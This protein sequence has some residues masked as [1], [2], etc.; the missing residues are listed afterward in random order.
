MNGK[1]MK[2]IALAVL[3]VLAVI[4]PLIAGPYPQSIMKTV[5][6]YMA[7]ALAWDILLRSG[8]L[9]FGIAGFYGLGAYA[10]VLAVIHLPVGSV[11][12]VLIGGV[13]SALVAFL[14]GVVILRLRAMYFAITTL[15]LGEIFR[16]IIRN[17]KGFAGGPEGLILPSVAFDGASWP[18]YLL[19]LA[20][21]LIVIG[22]SE[23]IEKGR[24]R[25]SLTAIR[26]N[27]IVAMSR[28]V[29]V[30]S[31]LLKVFILSSALMG[32]A[33][34]AFAQ[35]YGFVTPENTFS[36]DYTL[37]PLAMALLGGIYGTWGPVIGALVLGII[38]EYLRLFIPYGHLIVYGIIIILVIL[39]M[40]HGFV[41]L[42][43]DL[44]A[45]RKSGKKDAGSDSESEKEVPA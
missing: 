25:F 11:G 28:G 39:F 10:S 21:I 20:V 13:F 27:E 1:T 18:S 26:N 19:V 43:R 4:F 24:F 5:Y 23:F 17:W 30:Y 32:M 42:A 8:Q 33:G 34:A 3:L 37:L 45:R 35:L 15:A 36:S 6:V 31:S 38:A 12:G 16:I 44:T 14:F 22:A 2:R 29:N 40:P 9:S 7:L 41:G